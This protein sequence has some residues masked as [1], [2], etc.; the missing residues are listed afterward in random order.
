TSIVLSISGL[1]DLGSSSS[2]KVA[3][4]SVISFPRSPHPTYTMIV[5]SLHFASCCWETVFPEPN[6]PGMAAVPPFA[7]GKN[8]SKTL[9]PVKRGVSG[10]SFL[11][12]G[13]GD[14][15]LHLLA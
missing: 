11:D 3:R 4:T 10:A 7:T 6:G 15:T 13:L 9:W 14:L 8:V 12:M 2:G 5:L 1:F